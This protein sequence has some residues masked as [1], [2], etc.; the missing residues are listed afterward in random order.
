MDHVCEAC[1]NFRLLIGIRLTVVN[2]DNISLF[3][4]L[5]ITASRSKGIEVQIMLIPFTK[6]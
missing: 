3:E 2:L 6:T 1:Y 5:F 4:T